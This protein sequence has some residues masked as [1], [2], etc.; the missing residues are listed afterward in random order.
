MERALN[1]EALALALGEHAHLPSAQDLQRLLAQAEV[2]LFL[3]SR[4]S[5]TRCRQP[6]SY[7]HGVSSPAAFDLYSAA[8][9]RRA[10][11]VSAHILDLAMQDRGRAR[12]DRCRL[13]F[14]AAVGYRRG[15]LE[16]NAMAVF[17][18]ARPILLSVDDGLI[19]RLPF[20]PFEIGLTV[21]GF[22]T[23]ALA[24][25]ASRLR[26][27]FAELRREIDLEDLGPTSF[28]PL[29]QIVEAADRIRQFLF[30]GNAQRL[31]EAQDFLR[32]AAA[33]R[34][35]SAPSTTGGLQLTFSR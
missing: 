27:Q 6:V 31:A 3:T 13:A 9:Q 26:R 1:R 5:L 20:V 15:E 11:Q 16:P 32:A 4:A 28:G 23:R 18:R 7:L 25:L 17:R 22:E 10:F 34:R 35:T 19:D 33:P 24:D 30:R 8:R 21:L 14:G 12:L 2:N 29:D